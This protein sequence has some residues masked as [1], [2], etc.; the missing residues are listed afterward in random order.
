MEKATLT[1]AEA[2]QVLGINKI[3]MYDI[4]ERADFDALIRIGRKKLILTHK[5]LTWMD[6]Q[7]EKGKVI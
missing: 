4:T 1:V 6:R 7:T 3:K 5:F 2:A